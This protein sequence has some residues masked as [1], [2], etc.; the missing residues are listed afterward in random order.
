MRD[1]HCTTGKCDFIAQGDRDDDILDQAGRHAEQT[2]GMHLSRDERE[3]MRGMIHDTDSL[4]HQDAI[5]K[6]T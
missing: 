3:Q 2:H 4:I 5:A 6:R 1:Y